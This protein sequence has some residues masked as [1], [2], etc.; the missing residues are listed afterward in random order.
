[1]R[2][3]IV[4]DEPG[5]RSFLCRAVEYLVPGAAVAERADGYLG[6][7]AFLAEPADLVISDHRMPQM[8]GLELLHA[9]RAR[10]AVPFIMISAEPSIERAARVAGAS[11]FLNKPATLD[12]LRLAIRSALASSIDYTNPCAK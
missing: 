10:S 8:S 9:L 4:E 12:D 1:M 3:L 11:A 2:V 5:V 7:L 6:L